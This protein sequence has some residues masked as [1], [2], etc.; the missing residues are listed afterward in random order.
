MK[1]REEYQASIYAKR[2]ALLAKRKK[3]ITAAV[4]GV[5]AVILLT[6]SVTAIPSFTKII[7]DKSET[8]AHHTE[9]VLN[10]NEADPFADSYGKI[11]ENESTLTTLTNIQKYDSE[12]VAEAVTETAPERITMAV[13]YPVTKTHSNFEQ[14]VVD[15]AEEL[16]GAVQSNKDGIG[17]AIADFINGFTEPDYAPETGGDD[18]DN[19]KPEGADESADYTQDE[20]ISAAMN[21]LPDG[22]RQYAVPDK[23]FVTVTRT[24]D[25]EEYYEVRFEISGKKHKVMLNAENLDMIAVSSSDAS[26]ASQTQISPPYIPEQ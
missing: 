13:N 21:Y 3:N 24:S 6:V 23:A 20:I 22:A 25:G 26:S 4:T 10:K 16:T 2:D 7:S 8:T 18:I 14:N 12:T 9:S 15:S 5:A 19:V 1:S 11:E 17:S